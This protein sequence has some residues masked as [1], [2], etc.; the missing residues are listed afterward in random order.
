MNNFLTETHKNQST[1]PQDFKPIKNPYIV[2]N[3]IKSTDMFFGR[4]EVFKNLQDGIVNDGAHVV[5]LVAGRRSGKTSILWQILGGRFHEVAEAVLC[6]FHQ[7]VPRIKQN[8]D[9]PF[10][11][12]KAILANPNFKPYE[13][14]F[15][16]EDETS[17]TDRLEQLVQNCSNLI[18]PR[19]L[20]ILCDEAEAIEA[21]FKSI[22]LSANA[23]LWLKKILNLPVHFV[24]TSTREFE[25]STIKTIL[26]PATQIYPIEELSLLETVAL[27]QNP[28]E[29]DLTYQE[30]VL[31]RIY[32]LSGGHP[33]YVQ[34]ICHTLVN[35]INAEFKRYQVV[36]E[37]LEDI[38][39]FIVRNPTGH[40]QET[41][42]SLSN[43]SRYAPRYAREAL[44]ALANTIRHS[45]EYVS[46]SKI[47]K[48]VLKKQFNIDEPT[49][50]KTLAW[51]FKN[52][53]LLEKQSENYR[54]RN[55]LLRYW[56]SHEF[57][58]G[59]DIDP[60]VGYF[61]SL[62]PRSGHSLS[63]EKKGEVYAK[64]LETFLKEGTITVRGRIELDKALKE[65][66]L[67]K[68]QA[69]EIENKIRE[70]CHLKPIRWGQEYQDSYYFLKGQYASKIP[71]HELKLLQNTYVSTNRIFASKAKE[72]SRYFLP[73]QSGLR[74]RY[75]WGGIVVAVGIIA[76]VAWYFFT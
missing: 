18:K 55:D 57:K 42:A 32:R 68:K 30:K 27:I 66:R 69:Q 61:A 52:T 38:I 56:I 72:I 23:L 19:K 10:E 74:S 75:L 51:F 41:W 70:I 8:E 1:I 47:F 44:A 60:L 59:A 54:F 67:E 76:V 31:D 49:L 14:D 63:S 25:T 16:K 73:S 2:G 21:L 71:K 7:I 12:G 3:P 29:Q 36:D 43:P 34:Y 45:K 5:L 53:R 15:L 65:L 13:A 58:T 20:I 17:W 46:A 4:Q 39:D 22:V 33:F 26:N 64:K 24:M 50:H 37:D 28:V 35:H 48:T 11:V 9:F 40:I 6:D 62:T